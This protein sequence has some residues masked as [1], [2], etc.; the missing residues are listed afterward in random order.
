M[1]K[2]KVR[3]QNVSEPRFNISI[4]DLSLEEMKAL[5]TYFESLN[6]KNAMVRPIVQTLVKT[7]K[8][9]LINT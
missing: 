7:S 8:T 1:T 3:A 6:P 4:E 5:S 2:A 9:V